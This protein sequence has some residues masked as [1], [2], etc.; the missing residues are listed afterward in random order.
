MTKAEAREAGMLATALDAL[1]ELIRDVVAECD[2]PDP[3]NVRWDGLKLELWGYGADNPDS[4]Q[5]VGDGLILPLA[6]V[7]PLLEVIGRKI[8]ARLVELGVEP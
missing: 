6:F 1:P 4:T 7:G 5:H 2:E 8:A 3:P